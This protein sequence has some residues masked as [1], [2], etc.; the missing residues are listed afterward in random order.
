MRTVL[1]EKQL[2]LLKSCYHA[3][4]RPDALMKEQLVEMTG[5]SPRVVRVWFQNK[6]CKDKKKMIIKQGRVS[7][8]PDDTQ[9]YFIFIAC[10]FHTVRSALSD[11]KCISRHPPPATDAKSRKFDPFR[12]P[13]GSVI[14]IIVYIELEQHCVVTFSPADKS[15]FELHIA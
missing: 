4:P 15:H 5:L 9:Q 3:N 6:R 2:N 14:T 1:T 7:C 12:L 11:Q 13:N 10:D 8:V